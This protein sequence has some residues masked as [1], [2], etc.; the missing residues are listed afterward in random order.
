MQLLNYGRDVI[1]KLIEEP[2]IRDI[3][4]PTLYHPDLHKRNIFV[5][6]SDPTIV[7]DIIDWQSSSIDPIFMYGDHVPDFAGFASCTSSEVNTPEQNADLCVQAFEVCLLGR[8]PNLAAARRMDD[9]LL[10]PFHYCHRTWKDG[11]TVFRQE[12]IELARRWEHLG[13]SDV[14]P[15]PLPDAEEGLVQQQ[16]YKSFEIAHDLKRKL[17]DLLEVPSDGWVPIDRWQATLAFHQEAFNEIVQS[18]E[19]TEGTEDG[20]VT[21]DEIKKMWPFDHPCE[22]QSLHQSED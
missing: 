22:G 11:A 18:V 21:A 5:S 12:L 7:T 16:D 9:D 14:C 6:G 10:R 20:D 3:A 17:M 19:K 13:L 15:Y 1:H 8:I 2:C 4:T